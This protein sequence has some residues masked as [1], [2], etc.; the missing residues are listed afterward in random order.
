MHIQWKNALYC[1]DYSTHSEA[2]D[3]CTLNWLLKFYPKA[4]GE[5]FGK[6]LFLFV[7]G[8]LKQRIKYL[9]HF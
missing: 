3:W 5:G 7:K 8:E 4:A 6:K 9:P 2:P 1:S